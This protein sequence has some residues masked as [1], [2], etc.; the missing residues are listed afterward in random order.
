MFDEITIKRDFAEWWRAYPLKV[1]KLAAEQKY[2]AARTKR[3]ASAQDL[4]TGLA[5]YIAH[6]PEWQHY[7]NPG[8]WLHQGRWMDDYSKAAPAEKPQARVPLAYRPYVPLRLRQE[9]G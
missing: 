9:N 8:T 5:Q 7:A 2:R 1:G 4:L 3:K 6:K